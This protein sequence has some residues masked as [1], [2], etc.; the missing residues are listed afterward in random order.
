MQDERSS[1]IKV[2]NIKLFQALAYG[3]D[4]SLNEYRQS[5]LNLEKEYLDEKMF[6]VS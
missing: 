6:I 5:I 4:L 1:Y 3:I 2:I